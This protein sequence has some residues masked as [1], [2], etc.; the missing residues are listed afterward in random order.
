LSRQ[1][2]FACV[3]DKD[4]FEK[5]GVRQLQAGKDYF[6]E[7]IEKDGKP[8]LGAMTPVPVVMQKC[9][10]RRPN[11]ADAK[12]GSSRWSNELHFAHRKRPEGTAETDVSAGLFEGY[13]PAMDHL[14]QLR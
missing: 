8:Y 12:K 6:E 10:M 3:A 4:E 5:Q 1:T 9:V 2:A 14:V 13:R 7:V 11:Y